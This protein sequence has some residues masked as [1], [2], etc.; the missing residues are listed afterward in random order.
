[1][2]KQKISQ[3]LNTKIS[4]RQIQFLGLVQTS[5]MDLDKKIDKELE[6]NPALEEDEVIN[7]EEDEVFLTRKT[8][9]KSFIHERADI[10]KEISLSEFLNSQLVAAKVS[11]ELLFIIK[12]LINSLDVNGFLTRDLYSISSDLL[13]SYNLDINEGEII[14]AL[15]Y[16]KQLDPAGVGAKNIK[17]SLILQL[18]RKSNKT[19]IKDAKF[20]LENYFNEFSNKN[21]TKLKERLNISSEMLKLIYN[22][23]EKLNP[24]PGRQYSKDNEPNTEVIP[25]FIIEYNNN[26]LKLRLNKTKKRTLKTS[27]YYKKL[28]LESNDPETSVFLEKQINKADW[29]QNSILERR[30]TLEKIMATILN[31]QK[32]YFL[33]GDE[34]DLKPMRLSDIAEIVKMDISTISR[35]SNSKYFETNFGVFLIKDLFSEAYGKKNGEIIST[36]S[37]KNKIKEIVSFENKSSPLTDDKI[38]VLLEKDDFFI[39]RRTVAKYRE[40]LK[41]PISRL[42]KSL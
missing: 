10:N 8:Y 27:N 2:Q 13:T 20:I 6:E 17:E 11:E 29:F 36:K 37:I 35:F 39:S 12:Y 32:K 1:M 40:A 30:K 22:E 34:K 42:R 41:I 3:K 24:F 16:I 7:D 25:D 5:I 23:I 18:N 28:L 38:T 26:E 15:N 33:S 19:V 31:F 14:E 9:D 4:L 21:F